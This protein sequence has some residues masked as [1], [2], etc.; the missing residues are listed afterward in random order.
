MCRCSIQNSKKNDNKYE[1]ICIKLK[2]EVGMAVP[3]ST[4]TRVVG[5]ITSN[6]KKHTKTPTLFLRSLSYHH[7]VAS[8]AQRYI[9]CSE[10]TKIGSL[11]SCTCITWHCTIMR[12]ASVGMYHIIIKLCDCSYY[13]CLGTFWHCYPDFT[14]QQMFLHLCKQV[15]WIITYKVYSHACFSGYELLQ[16]MCVCWCTLACP[17]HISEP[18]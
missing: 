4:Q 16:C 13:S 8:W 2:G 5:I 18:S 9:I 10:Q 14:L 11:A 15:L 3:K 7:L 6:Y 17:L 12:K 1:N